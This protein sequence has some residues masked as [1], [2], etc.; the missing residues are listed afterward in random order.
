MT[1]EE[2]WFK[3]FGNLSKE[4]NVVAIKVYQYAT[5]RAAGIAEKECG[6]QLAAGICPKYRYCMAHEIAQKIRE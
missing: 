4:P 6:E 5:E 2:W 1:F 3:N